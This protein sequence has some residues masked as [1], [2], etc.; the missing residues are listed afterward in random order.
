MTNRVTIFIS[1]MMGSTGRLLCYGPWIV[2]DGDSQ[3]PLLWKADCVVE[4][5]RLNRM[6]QP[7]CSPK[8]SHRATWKL[9]NWKS[10]CLLWNSYL[11]AWQEIVARYLANNSAWPCEWIVWLEV[12]SHTNLAWCILSEGIEIFSLRCHLKPIIHRSLTSF[13]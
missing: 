4:A 5:Q 3:H 1:W 9:T 11:Q 7:M 10:Q 2:I 12:I 8:N 6:C 13:R